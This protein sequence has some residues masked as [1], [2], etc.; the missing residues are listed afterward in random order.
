MMFHLFHH[1]DSQ[2]IV[3]SASFFQNINTE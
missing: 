3:P 2:I 1:Q